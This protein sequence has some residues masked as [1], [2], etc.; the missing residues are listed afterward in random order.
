MLT[1]ITIRDLAI[2][3]A[4]EL[5]LAG[6]LT[7]LTGETGAGK[8]IIVDALMLVAGNRADTGMIRAGAERCEVAASFDTD[9]LPDALR[10][11]L[12][13]AAIHTDGELLL[14]RVINAD[15]RSRAFVNGQ[16]VPLQM[17]RDIAGFLLEVHGQ[18]EFQSLVRPAAQRELLDTY[19][20]LDERARGVRAAH[21]QWRELNQ[22]VEAAESTLRT[23]DARLDLLRF[24]DTELTALDLKPGEV[25]ELTAEAARLANRGK[26]LAGAQLAA[27]LLYEGEEDTAQARLAR[28]LSA[29][30]PLAG[31]DEELAPIVPMLD[32][33]SIRITEAA[34][35]LS[36][37]ADGLDLDNG[38]QAQVEKRL[39]ATEELARKHRVAPAQLPAHHE[40][41]RQELVSLEAADAD[42]AELRVRRD[43]ALAEWRRQA[44]ELSE[45]R[46]SAAHTFSREITARM[47]Q[48]GM[49]GG[50]FE[51]SVVAQPDA[52]PAAHGLDAVE[53]QVTANP[54]QPLRPLAKV[55]SGGELARLS[56]AVQ[57]ACVAEERR[58]M[59]FDE[60]DSG[61]GG[62]IAEVVGRQLRAL[63]VNGQVLCVTH[64][65]QV[66][67][68][69]H[70]QLKVAKTT[71]SGETRTQLTRLTA[72]QR[73][74]EIARMLGGAVVSTKA[75]AHAQEMLNAAASQDQETARIKR[76][77]RARAAQT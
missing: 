10:N 23:R 72:K 4:L 73:G 46:L 69:G 31:L 43:A 30:R 56:L 71:A 49:E 28:A 7:V 55:A 68:Q 18:H 26:L 9:Y 61:I 64:L 36:R 53:F 1:H 25:E 59:V 11:M 54:G 52:T 2:V 41:L 65:P 29:L 42:Y 17:L 75:L 50:R 6:G 16:A 33:A 34:R 48:L 60:V 15:G 39:A 20:R 51:V 47:Q 77:T 74:P 57:V 12:E 5:E 19:G 76:P 70:H 21:A 45:A 32:E 37:Y 13:E 24:Q 40:A 27:Q 58:C 22:Q 38:R 62:G 63:G 35:E 8:S 66:A 14:R 3:D 44:E 67:A